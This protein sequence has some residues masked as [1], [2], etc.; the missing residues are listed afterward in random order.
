MNLQQSQGHQIQQHQHS[1]QMQQNQP[2]QQQQHQFTPAP[3]STIPQIPAHIMAGVQGICDFDIESVP[4]QFR[5][6][7]D[8][9]AVA[10]NPK[11]SVLQG[12]RLNVDLIQSLEHDSVV[13]CIRFSLCGKLLATGCN[14]YAQIFDVNTG[15]KIWYALKS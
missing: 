9:W 7:E 6:E 12:D 13:C 8:D 14:R 2:L 5:K 4:Q 15:Q 3:R 10:F 1:Q 11:S